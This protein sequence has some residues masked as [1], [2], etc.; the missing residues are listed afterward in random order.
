MFEKKKILRRL[1]F[2]GI[3]SAI[4]LASAALIYLLAGNWHFFALGIYG[5]FSRVVSGFLGLIF[6]AVPF[7][8]VEIL[9][10]GLILGCAVYFF[11][12]AVK[13]FHPQKRLALLRWIGDTVICL[14]AIFFLFTLF[15]GGCYLA[16]KLEERMGLDVRPR[17]EETLADTARWLLGQLKEEAAAVTRDQ[18]GVTDGGG[19]AALAAK[20]PACVEALRDEN[21]ELY[22]GGLVSPPQRPLLS[23]LMSYAG[24]GGIYIPITGECH[25]NGNMADSDLP[26]CMAHE[27]A[28]RLGCAPEEDANFVAYLACMKSQYPEIRYSGVKSAFFYCLSAIDNDEIYGQLVREIPDGVWTDIAHAANLGKRFEGPL[29]DSMT[30]MSS[31]MNDAYLQALGQEGGIKSYGR[32]TDLLIAYYVSLHGEG[33]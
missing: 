1:R 32:V 22:G 20:M 2:Q 19:F 4:L 17:P 7:S 27:M 24:I 9:L 12:A 14:A 30:D 10:C 3:L 8:V 25:V 21:P 6:S 33:G 28:H 16:P 18:N 5:P 15:W 26:S 23:D 11:T 31:S 13:T 29:Q